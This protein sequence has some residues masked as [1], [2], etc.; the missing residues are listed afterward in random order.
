MVGGWWLVGLYSPRVF[1]AN[2][3]YGLV[4]Q[5]LAILHFVRRRPETYWLWIILMFGGI[6]ALIYIVVEVIPDAGLLRGTFQVFPRRKRIKELEGLVL[7]NPSVGNWEELGDLYL[8]DAQ[9]A[10]ARECFD[11]VLAKV[12]SVDPFYRRAL[13]EL[14]LND[15]TAAARDLERVV[16]SE[17]KYD[18][19]RAAGLRAHALA[20]L[21][22]KEQADARFADVLQTSTLS[23]TQYNYACFLAAEG[24]TDEAREWADRILRKK[25][26]MPDYIRRRERPWF[27]KAKA[28]LKKL[29]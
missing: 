23:E 4:L 9:F 14:A 8:D 16:A 28:L 24:R 29:K 22:Q 11:K 7:D 5:A 12:E 1:G 19:Q 13:S 20:Q 6:G 26:T 2:Y 10:K 3:S 25:A 27:R 15:F 17:P 21:G 18:Y